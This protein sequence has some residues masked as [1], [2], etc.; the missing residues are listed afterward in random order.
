MGNMICGQ[1]QNNHGDD[2]YLVDIY[3]HRPTGEA[4]EDLLTQLMVVDWE[5]AGRGEKIFWHNCVCVFSFVFNFCPFIC[6]YRVE[7]F[8]S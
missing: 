3:D 4:K 6:V 2:D 1:Y 5:E 8:D 7:E